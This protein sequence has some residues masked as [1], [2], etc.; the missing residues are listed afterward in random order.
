MPKDIS[1]ELAVTNYQ[2]VHNQSGGNARIDFANGTAAVLTISRPEFAVSDIFVASTYK[3][4]KALKIAGKGLIREFE[5][6]LGTGEEEDRLPLKRFSTDKTVNRLI[7][8]VSTVPREER[9]AAFAR[10]AIPFKNFWLEMPYKDAD[11]SR[12]RLAHWCTVSADA[13]NV[14]TY[15]YKIIDKPLPSGM[16]AIALPTNDP[17][18]IYRD[19]IDFE[20]AIRRQKDPNPDNINRS[21]GI[22][23]KRSD[24]LLSMLII[25]GSRRFNTELFRPETPE[26]HQ[27]RIEEFRKNR[28]RVRVGLRP[29]FP[30]HPIKVE[31]GPHLE[32]AIRKGK[33]KQ[34]K[35]MLGITSVIE[36][37]MHIKKL[38]R[39]VTRHSHERSFPSDVPVDR[40]GVVR[41]AHAAPPLSNVALPDGARLEDAL[42]LLSEPRSQPKSILSY[43]PK[44]K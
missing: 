43:T 41:Q 14:A 3:N 42:K 28:G 1:Q 29:Q 19:R 2:L 9:L 17:I 22:M 34:V 26:E 5:A 25:L 20:E 44:P 37:P 30:L 7:A 13:L 35:Q 8:L 40:R 23:N 18:T 24:E 31:I 11:N 32:E 27:Q 38:G 36:H 15:Y 21:I 39:T 33:I 16:R 12:L 6:L 10:I 4:Y